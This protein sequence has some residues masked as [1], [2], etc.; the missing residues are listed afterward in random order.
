MKGNPCSLGHNPFL[1][2]E[3]GH[4]NVETLRHDKRYFT[5][6]DKMHGLFESSRDVIKRAIQDCTNRLCSSQ[7]YG[8]NEDRDKPIFDSGRARL[9]AS[10]EARRIAAN[11]AK[12]AELLQ[13]WRI[14]ANFAKMPEVRKPG[15]PRC[16][17]NHRPAVCPP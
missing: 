11:F 3:S 17:A 8:R 16:D 12:L 13:A 1:V 10:D 9:V 5:E 7:E 14:A 4:P 6:K 2:D 15:R